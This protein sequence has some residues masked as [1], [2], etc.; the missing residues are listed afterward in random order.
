MADQPLEATFK[1]LRK[2]LQPYERTLL[3][4]VDEPGNYQLSSP[5]MSDRIGRPLFV[6]AV[7]TKKRYVTFHLMPVYACPDLVKGLSPSLRKRMQGKSC[8]NFTSIGPR[9][10][11]ELSALTK[12]GIARYRMIKLPW[13]E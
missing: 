1:T 2:V 8:F 12:K 9:D 3:V 11:R 13:S 7:Q 4:A 6:A 10:A 5:A